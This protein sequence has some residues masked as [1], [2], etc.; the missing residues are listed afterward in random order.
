MNDAFAMIER[1]DV[2]RRKLTSVLDSCE[3][4]MAQLG[5]DGVVSLLQAL[6]KRLDSERLKVLILGQFKQGKSTLINALLGDEVL[7]AFA[8][9]CTA[10]INEIKYGDHKRAVVHFRD[11]VTNPLPESLAENAREHIAAH[12]GKNVP[13]LEICVEDI[14]SYV[15]IPDPGKDHGESVAESPFRLVEIYWPLELCRNGVEIIDSPGLNEHGTRTRVTVDYLGDVDAVA[16]VLSCIALAGESEMTFIENNLRLAGHED[17][18]FCCNRF[19][20][21]RE[22]ERQRV[23]DFGQD[24]LSKLTALG[25]DGVFFVSALD[26]LEG[27]LESAPAKLERSGLVPFETRLSRF[28]GESRGRL[29]LL[30]PARQLITEVTKALNE[31]IP[32]QQRMLHAD[33]AELEKRWQDAQ[34]ALQQAETRCRQVVEQVERERERISI[35]VEEKICTYVRSLAD[36]IPQWVAGYEPKNPIKFFSFDT[37]PQ[38]AK[39]LVKEVSEFVNGRIESAMARWQADDLMPWL[40]G[41]M[42]SISEGIRD[43]VEQI[44]AGL[45]RVKH[46]L[47]GEALA[48]EHDKSALE[49]VLSAGAGWVLMGPGGAMLGGMFGYQEMLKALLPQFALYVGAV[50]IGITNPLTIIAL[51]FGSSTIQGMLKVGTMTDKL[52]QKCGEQIATELRTHAAQ[53][54][55]DGAQGVHAKT[56]VVQDQ[57]KAGL[58]KEVQSVTDVTNAVL[59]EKKRGAAAIEQ[60]LTDLTAIADTL[61]GAQTTL[62]DV[63]F[64]LAH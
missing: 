33:T 17:I 11:P 34:P 58:D 45:S 35:D 2:C 21:V 54:A 15:V 22:K 49:R 48:A 9:P 36:E 12:G 60:R 42:E 63:V 59:R 28:L 43:S 32:Q 18:F 23:I 62:Q 57:I 29:K 51:L 64:D 61:R 41:R 53:I 50:L 40:L 19:D 56:Q 7:P 31:V 24:K 1:F 47:N 8:V 46:D 5:S 44:A 55:K 27:R 10:V 39:Q 38:Q 4:A 6:R 52:K 14:E 13:P 25:R 3:P 30:Q 20:Q 26:A 37:S 16:F